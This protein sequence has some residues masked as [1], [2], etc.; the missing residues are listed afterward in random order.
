MLIQLVCRPACQPV[1]LLKNLHSV[2]ILLPKNESLDDTIAFHGIVSNCVPTAEF[3]SHKRCHR[4]IMNNQLTG[5]LKEKIRACIN[6]LPQ[7]VSEQQMDIIEC[8]F[9]ITVGTGQPRQ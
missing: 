6:V 5:M 7:F 8:I 3:I 4:T 2:Q 1:A 9:L